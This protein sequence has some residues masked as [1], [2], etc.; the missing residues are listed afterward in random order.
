MYAKCTI[1]HRASW[2]RAELTGSFF[3][4]NQYSSPQSSLI[5]EW[6]DKKGINTLKFKVWTDFPLSPQDPDSFYSALW[7]SQHEAGTAAG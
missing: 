6:E 4:S 7:S 3:R 5:E 1:S 2:W